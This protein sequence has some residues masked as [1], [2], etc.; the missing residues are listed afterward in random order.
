[1]RIHGAL[2]LAT[3]LLVAAPAIAQVE[4]VEPNDSIGQAQNIDFPSEAVLGTL[5]ITGTRSAADSD[6]FRLQGLTPGAEF[7]VENDAIQIGIGI[8]SAGGVLLDSIAF[9][10]E[11]ILFGTADG[12]GELIVAVCGRLGNTQELDC[13]AQGQGTSPYAVTVPEP[14]TLVGSGAA[15]LA[16]ASLRRR[17]R[18]RRVRA[19][20]D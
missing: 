17:M 1:M 4:E 7:Q 5:T 11:Q 2:A 3:A 19:P 20:T 15:L 16:I 8:F 14:G 18:R 13:S 12:N 6:Y 10:S 9:S